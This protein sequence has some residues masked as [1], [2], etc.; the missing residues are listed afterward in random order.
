MDIK[1]LLLVKTSQFQERSTFMN[2]EMMTLPLCSTQTTLLRGPLG[3]Q[4]MI[5]HITWQVRLAYSAWFWQYIILT[6]Q[7]L[8][9]LLNHTVKDFLPVCFFQRVHGH[10]GD[11][12]TVAECYNVYSQSS[13]SQ[14]SQTFL[15][16]DFSNTEQQ[17]SQR[18]NIQQLKFDHCLHRHLKPLEAPLGWYL[19]Y[20][21]CLSSQAKKNEEVTQII[22]Y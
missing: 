6:A 17:P 15:S 9:P 20:L 22:I 16:V 19:Y 3:E 18:A 10:T 11:T 13:N 8:I 2:W 12:S 4:S 1:Y 14:T 21:I 5:A 7:T